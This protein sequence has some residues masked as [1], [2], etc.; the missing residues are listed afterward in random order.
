M[1]IWGNGPWHSRALSH[2]SAACAGA[3]SSALHA[4]MAAS[5]T[6]LDVNDLIMIPSKKSTMALGFEAETTSK[7]GGCRPI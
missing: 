6:E 2:R 1:Q 3:P 7:S 5:N 4:M